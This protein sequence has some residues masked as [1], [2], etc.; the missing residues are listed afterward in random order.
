[1]FNIG[2]YVVYGRTVAIVTESEYGYAVVTPALFQSIERELPEEML[3]PA[4]VADVTREAYLDNGNIACDLNVS[5]ESIKDTFGITYEGKRCGWGG[6]HGR[7]S[8]IPAYVGAEVVRGIE[9]GT[10]VFSPDRPRLII[11]I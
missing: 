3:S 7:V 8:N 4:T 6:V 2:D 1:M 11:T 9:W 10:E 5:T